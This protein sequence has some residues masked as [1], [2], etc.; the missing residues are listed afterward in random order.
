MA[1]FFGCLWCRTCF[2]AHHFNF[3]RSKTQEQVYWVGYLVKTL[4]FGTSLAYLIRLY[5]SLRQIDFCTTLNARL[6]SNNL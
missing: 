4:F 2:D 6:Y 5:V 3:Y 1:F